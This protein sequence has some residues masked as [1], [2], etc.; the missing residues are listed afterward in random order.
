MKMIIRARPT[1]PCI[2]SELLLKFIIKKCQ[3]VI[4][5]GRESLPRIWVSLTLA[6]V[7]HD[8]EFY[9]QLKQV[10]SPSASVEKI[11]VMCNHIFLPALDR[12]DGV[13]TPEW[14]ASEQQYPPA[15]EKDYKRLLLYALREGQKMMDS[16]CYEW[17]KV[18]ECLTWIGL[19][20][21]DFRLCQFEAVRQS[22]EGD[23]EGLVRKGV[24]IIRVAAGVSPRNKN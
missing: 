10:I 11:L 15:K 9:D 1:G 24:E 20:Y 22:C 3:E 23:P 2:E 7:A 16:D 8:H 18:F 13:Q 5:Q 21:Y 12:L 14:V 4:Q 17:V 19:Q 6:A